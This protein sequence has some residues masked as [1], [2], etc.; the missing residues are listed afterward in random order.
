MSRG[1]RGQPDRSDGAGEYQCPPQARQTGGV[2]SIL[3]V[4]VGFL[5]GSIPVAQIAARLTTGTDLRA[6]DSG[7]VSGTNL[8]KVAGFLPLALAGVLEVAKGAIGP[9]L[10]G[11]DHTTLAAFAGGAAVIGHNWSPFLR[12]AGGRGISPSIGALLVTAWP[13]ALV[14]LA[15]LA[16]GRLLGRTGLGSF[17]ADVVLVPVTALTHG[18]AG[19]LAGISVVVPMLAKRLVGNTRPEDPGAGVYLNRLLF[20]RDTR[21]APG[22]ARD[23]D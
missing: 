2:Q 22:P 19:A 10:A 1:R 13:G 11:S 23:R 17:I 16:L 18:A 6:V 15:G 21:E 7:T 14:L 3:V 5:A 4:L 8:F 12:G 20:D 9:I